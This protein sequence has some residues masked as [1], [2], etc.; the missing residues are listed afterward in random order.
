MSGFRQNWQ[1]EVERRAD[2]RG[3]DDRRQGGGAVAA[4]A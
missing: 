3:S 1:V 2:D 4:P